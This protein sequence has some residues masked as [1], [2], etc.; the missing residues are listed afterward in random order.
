[1]EIWK[2]IKGFEGYY[3]V[4]DLG[5]I[6]SLDRYVNNS[7]S[8]KRLLRGMVMKIYT[9]PRTGYCLVT[10]KNC[11]AKTIFIHRLVA[12]AFIPNPDNKPEIN[13]KDGDKTNN[14]ASNLEWSTRQENIDHSWE[15]GLIKNF[16]EN[17]SHSIFTEKQILE[18]RENKDNLKQRQLAELYGT[19]QPVISKI[20]N[21][22]R[23]KH[24]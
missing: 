8:G 3:Q 11:G 24:I 4:S 6:R 20:V 16:G 15:T 14:Q 18:I 9:F 1:M 2:D 22:T 23:W 10:L 12:E 7:I 19:T 21:R 17:H 13:H 5:R